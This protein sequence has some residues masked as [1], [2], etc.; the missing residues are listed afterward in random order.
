MVFC[1][2]FCSV[3]WTDCW[4]F[5]NWLGQ[6]TLEGEVSLYCW[7]PVWLV[8]N[9]L[10]DCWHFSF[11]FAKQANPN[12]SNRRSTIQWYFPFSVPWLGLCLYTEKV[13]QEITRCFYEVPNLVKKDLE[14]SLCSCI[15][16]GTRES[17][18]IV[19]VSRDTAPRLK[20]YLI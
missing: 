14:W 16:H 7:P 12:R 5:P 1:W 10:Y 20:I 19:I 8:W 2:L 3:S 9:Q 18:G 13:L 6:G 17:I 4:V 11:L 15:T